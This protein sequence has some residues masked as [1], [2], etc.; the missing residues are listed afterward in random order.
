MRVKKHSCK[1]SPVILKYGFLNGSGGVYEGD[2]VLFIDGGKIGGMAY[3]AVCGKLK[4]FW[5]DGAIKFNSKIE[6]RKK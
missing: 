5:D 4:M 6:L 2:A 1:D 3:C